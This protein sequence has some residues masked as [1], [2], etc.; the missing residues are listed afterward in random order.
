MEIG[1]TSADPERTALP[2]GATSMRG[3]TW[4]MSGCNILRDGQ[5]MKEDYGQDLDRLDEGKIK[6]IGNYSL[7]WKLLVEIIG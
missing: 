1:V 2:S 4:V 6:Q 7:I 3:G 5:Q